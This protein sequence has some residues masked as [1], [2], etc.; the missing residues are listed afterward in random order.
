MLYFVELNAR[1]VARYQS[2][3]KAIDYVNRKKINLA[4]NCVYLWDSDGNFYDLR[5]NTLEEIAS[6]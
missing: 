1:V 5:G 6:L 3:K 4:Q 2:L